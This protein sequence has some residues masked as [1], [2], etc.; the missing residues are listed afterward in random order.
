M[1]RVTTHALLVLFSFLALG[2]AV[3][4]AQGTAG[5][6]APPS[7]GDVPHDATAKCTDGTWSSSKNKSGAC[8]SHGGVANWFGPAPK[9]TAARCKD[10]TW[11]KSAGSGACSS[12]GGVAYPVGQHAS[13]G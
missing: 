12:H 5:A 3:H 9:G 4:A 7:V 11:S 8:S 6:A 13:K 10:G 1:R 2:A